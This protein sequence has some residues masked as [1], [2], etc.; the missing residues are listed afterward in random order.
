MT[1]SALK[2]RPQKEVG[3]RNKASLSHPFSGASPRDRRRWN[4]ECV[5]SP[6]FLTPGPCLVPLNS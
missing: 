3:R 1:G 4:S 6:H 2:D 5:L